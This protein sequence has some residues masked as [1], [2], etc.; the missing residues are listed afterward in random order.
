MSPREV[1]PVVTVG[2]GDFLVVDNVEHEVT[3]VVIDT[4]HLFPVIVGVRAGWARAYRDTNEA[5]MVVRG[6]R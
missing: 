4:L 6:N 5:V 3:H 1:V 2:I